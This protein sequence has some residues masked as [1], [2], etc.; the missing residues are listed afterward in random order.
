[1]LV[2]PAWIGPSPGEWHTQVSLR[3]TSPIRSRAERNPPPN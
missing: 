3:F 1:V 2:G